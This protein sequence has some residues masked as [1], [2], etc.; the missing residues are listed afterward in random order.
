[1]DEHCIRPWRSSKLCR[2]RAQETH[3]AG[4]PPPSAEGVYPDVRR[5]LVPADT[6]EEHRHLVDALS[7]GSDKVKRL[8]EDGMVGIEGLGDEDE[9]QLASRPAAMVRSVSRR[10]ERAK[11]SGV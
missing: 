8:G 4:V 10:R 6:G 2:E 5:Q 7:E 11:S 3:A 9:S 1:M